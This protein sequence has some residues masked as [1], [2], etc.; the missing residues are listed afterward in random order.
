MPLSRSTLTSAV[1]AGVLATGL[2]ASALA[3]ASVSASTGAATEVYLAAGLRGANEVGAAGDA[4]GRATVVLKISGSRVTYA[5]RWNKIDLPSA[6]HV[7]L[8]ARGTNG[9]VKLP[10]FTQALPKT[11]LG[12]I[13][14]VDADPALI[15][16]L[17]HSPGGFYANLHNAKHPQG[18]VRG[19]FYRLVRPVD[20]GGVLNGSNHATLGSRADGAQEVQG[21]DGMKRGDQDGRGVWWLRP[22]GSVI[23]FTALWSGLGQVTGGHVHKG[24]PG[25]NGPVVADLIGAPNGL[26]ANLS[27]LAGEAPVRAA[28]VRRIAANPGRYYSNLHTTEFNGGAVRGKLSGQAFDHPRAVTA[29]VLRG[30]QVY[31]CAKQPGGGYAY[32]QHGAAARLRRGV[33]L[34]MAPGRPPRW[35]APDGSS[36]R[37]QVVARSSNGHRNLPALLL[38]AAPSGGSGGLLSHTTQILRVNTEGGLAPASACRPGTRALVP[39]RADYL[40]LG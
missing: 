29:D 22:H 33:V 37:G 13:G 34:T 11:V 39:Y 35:R 14:T 26:P 4:D 9:E 1:P 31:A 28:V 27:G 3:P 6:G 18:A 12:L 38:A 40:F 36:V 15:R 10:F 17:V 8:G 16:S 32:T 24:P 25:Q 30:R 20:L 5:I 23:G 2:L 21:N 19:Q 7:H